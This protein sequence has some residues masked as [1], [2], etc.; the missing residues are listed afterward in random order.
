MRRAELWKTYG[1]AAYAI[2]TRPLSK[3]E[4]KLLLKEFK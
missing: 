3:G 4:A 2:S 1:M